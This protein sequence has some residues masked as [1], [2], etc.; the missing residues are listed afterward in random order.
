L[1]KL[2]SSFASSSVVPAVPQFLEKR[3][4][5]SLAG[6]SCACITISKLLSFG[7]KGTPCPCTSTPGAI[8]DLIESFI[9][10]EIIGVRSA[11]LEVTVPFCN[12]LKKVYGQKVSLGLY[13]REYI[14]KSSR[15]FRSPQSQRWAQGCYFWAC[16]NCSRS[17]INGGKLFW[18][19][20]HRIL[21]L[22]P[23]YS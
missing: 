11:T 20:S 9:F 13:G 1:T 10:G 16:S 14:S 21:S 23:K 2:I 6:K 15:H 4:E 8:D 5:P 19:V 18:T 17:G 12:A 22:T 3:K 7:T